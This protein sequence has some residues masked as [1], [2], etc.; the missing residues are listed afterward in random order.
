MNL[1]QKID[2]LLLLFATN[3]VL[4]GAGLSIRVM[5]DLGSFRRANRNK[6]LRDLEAKGEYEKIVDLASIYLETWPNE[7]NFKWFRA[8]ALFSSEK[9]DEALKY[10]E[11]LKENEPMLA[12][13]AEK[14]IRAINE[15]STATT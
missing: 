5:R 7:Y 10:F 14:Y 15:K 13:D 11:E 4:F 2:L 1:E 3:I 6:K 8:S 9:Y 12:E